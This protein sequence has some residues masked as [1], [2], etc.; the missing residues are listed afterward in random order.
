MEPKLNTSSIAENPVPNGFPLQSIA[1][2]IT[3]NRQD[4][5]SQIIAIA[6]PVYAGMLDFGCS[7]VDRGDVLIAIKLRGN[8][9]TR[10]REVR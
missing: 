6:V 9:L 2:V 1:L 8:D 7:G 10:G 4:I 3:G 5:D